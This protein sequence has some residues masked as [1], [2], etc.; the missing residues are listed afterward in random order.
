MN[1]VVDAVKLNKSHSKVFALALADFRSVIAKMDSLPADEIRELLLESFP[2]LVERY[3]DVAAAAAAEFYEE[4]RA[5][6]IGGNYQALLSAVGDVEELRRLLLWGMQ[7]LPETGVTQ[8]VSSKLG[9]IL[10]QQVVNRSRDTILLNVKKDPEKPRWARVPTGA[11][12]CAF[13]MLLASRGFEYSTRESAGSNKFHAH[14]DCAIV[15]GW[16]E[17]PRVRGYKP[18]KFKKVYEASVVSGDLKETLSNM[19][20]QFP[21]LVTDST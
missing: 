8:S 14:C 9:G 3:G 6:A 19:R 7:S 20:K 12:T 13:C 17:N 21:D 11:K 2:A 5:A 15:P 10:Q 4:A 16:G 18:E 1:A